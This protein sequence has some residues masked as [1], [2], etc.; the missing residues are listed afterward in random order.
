MSGRRVVAVV[1]AATLLAACGSSPRRSLG[2]M[3]DVLAAL[4]SRGVAVHETVSG[5]PG[6][7][8]PE[9]RDNSLRMTVSML[10]EARTHIVYLFRW[11][12]TTDFADSRADFLG[13]LA[14]MQS[15]APAVDVTSVESEPWRAYSVGWPEA[16]RLAVLGALRAAGGA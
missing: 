13:C 16:L 2:T 9:L 12:R 10:G 3:D 7:P 1:V 6:C 14:E 5:D 15:T 8:S 11:R 4:A